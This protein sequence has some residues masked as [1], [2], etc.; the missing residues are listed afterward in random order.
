M[1]FPSLKLSVVGGRPFSHGGDQLFRKKLLVK[2]LAFNFH[3]VNA[4]S[5]KQIFAC[6]GL[7]NG[8]QTIDSF[9]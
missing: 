5:W 6:T 3:C 4:S 7:G 8:E 1:D 2:R 9:I